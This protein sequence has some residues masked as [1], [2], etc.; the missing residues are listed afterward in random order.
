MLRASLKHAAPPHQYLKK[1]KQLEREI[2]RRPC[3]MEYAH[4]A[5]RSNASFH[6]DDASEEIIMESNRM[7]DVI[8]T[9]SEAMVPAMLV[10][11]SV[12]TLFF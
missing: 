4:V 8:R 1:G 2:V 5:K 6:R 9:L 12:E 3:E 10:C 11:K 7:G